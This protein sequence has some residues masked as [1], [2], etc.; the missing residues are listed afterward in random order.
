MEPRVSSQFIGRLRTQSTTTQAHYRLC[1]E[2]HSGGGTRPSKKTIGA[3][4]G[5]ADPA[6]SK[7]NERKT[8]T[9]AD[10]IDVFLT[11]HVEAKR[12]LGTQGHYRDI[13]NRI[14]RPEIGHKG[15][16]GSP[17]GIARLHL[18]WKKT[19]YQANRILAV[20]GS[21][22]AFGGKRGL[23]PETST[24]HGGLRS[25]KNRAESGF[26]QVGELEKLGSALRLAET[27]GIPW[28]IEEGQADRQ[29]HSK[30]CSPNGDRSSRGWRA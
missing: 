23:V 19:P 12:K 24:L 20:V 14:I 9:I 26:S 16:Q 15:R 22:Y 25:F 3:V 21:M 29:T 7:S 17:C 6:A 8:L 27:D 2:D 11:D 30:R 1:C 18:K 10:L 4:A 28:R 5:G 13:L